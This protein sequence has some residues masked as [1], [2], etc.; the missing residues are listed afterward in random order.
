ML[1][2]T[3]CVYGIA[4]VAPERELA[5]TAAALWTLLVTGMLIPRLR[6]YLTPGGADADRARADRHRRQASG[7]NPVHQLDDHC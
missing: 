3:V 2:L 6:R 7:S 5:T 4:Y 1:N